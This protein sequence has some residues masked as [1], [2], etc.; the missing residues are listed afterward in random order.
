M[1]YLYLKFAVCRNCDDISVFVFLKVVYVGG[2]QTDFL[3]RVK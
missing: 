3:G 1:V 2:C